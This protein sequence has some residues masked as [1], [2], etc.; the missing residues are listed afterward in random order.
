[1]K[2]GFLQAKTGQY[3]NAIATYE[4]LLTKFSKSSIA[5]DRAQFS[6]GDVYQYGLKD[7]AK[8]IAAYEKLLADYPQSLLADQAR[9]RIR[10]LRGDLM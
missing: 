1:M 5:L 6:I 3:A 2:V 7:N 10:A 4:T 8:A 9:Q